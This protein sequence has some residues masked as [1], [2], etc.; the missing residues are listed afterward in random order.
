MVLLIGG[1]CEVHTVEM[2]SG[3]MTYMPNVVTILS[4][5]QVILTL[6]I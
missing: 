4:S 1:M 2:D 6:L 3:G 5:I